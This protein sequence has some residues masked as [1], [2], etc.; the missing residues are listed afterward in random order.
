MATKWKNIKYNKFSKSIAFILAVLLLTSSLTIF[1][2]LVKNTKNITW[3]AAFENNYLESKSLEYEL[4]NITRNLK[5]VSKQYKSEAYIKNGGTLDKDIDNYYNYSW[6]LQNLYRDFKN[7]FYRNSS[8]Q[9][10]AVPEKVLISQFEKEYAEEIKLYKDAHIDHELNSYYSLVKKV[11]QTNGL[12]YYMSSTDSEYT[13]VSDKSTKFFKSQP[14]H[15]LFDKNGYTTSYVASPEFRY[16]EEDLSY[17]P[18]DILYVGLNDVFLNPKI[19]QWNA[20][21][22]IL[23]PTLMRI[24]LLMMGFIICLIYLLYTCGR[25]SDDE[26]IHLLSTD[27]IYIDVNII[28]TTAIMS[29]CIAVACKLFD[30]VRYFY[31]IPLLAISSLVSINLLL[32]I[33]KHIKNK[34]I[35]THNLSSKILLKLY[36]FV[37][38]LFSSA[39][40]A[41]RMLPTPNKANDFKNIIEGVEHIKNGEL[42][43]MIKTSNTGI[44]GKLA[45]DINGITDGLK[46][47]VNNE[48]KSERLKTELISNVS[49]DIRTPLTS[50]IT[51]IDLL[52]KEG[53]HSENA[54]KYLDVLDQKSLRL[55]TLTDDLFEASKASS[56][57]IPVHLE[58]IDIISLLTQGMGELDD[59]IISSELDFKFNY[60][61]EKV[62]VK[63]D[64][65]LLWRVIE[66]LMSNIFKY[67][68]KKSRV[69]IDVI[70]SEHSTS[71]IIKNI[72]AYELNIDEHEL[73]ERFKRGDESRNSEG[74]GLG[75]SIAKSLIELQNG[76]FHIEIDGDLFKSIVIIPK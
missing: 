51:Y 75:L 72:S 42:D 61:K 34:T 15:I 9:Y 76:K 49:H 64:G 44:Y 24:G 17:Y 38:G 28:A 53:F 2:Y 45:D 20:D 47:A 71:I 13:N 62:F 48:L 30:D 16:E 36:S 50:I 69:Y 58:N 74:S 73:M 46:A 5:Q 68:L 1:V 21:R 63:A 10:N 19:K 18:Q 6:K 33:L 12:Y 23:V 59:K 31:L 67:A 66:N 54:E 11:N 60:P 65:K 32:S 7:D 4:R 35:I 14:V 40:I 26:K 41:L 70:D 8:K 27:R 3:E 39:P 29:I 25:R 56:G 55:K 22:K 52:K 57:N 37:K 43:Y